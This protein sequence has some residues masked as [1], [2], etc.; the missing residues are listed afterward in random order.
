[1]ETNLGGPLSLLCEHNLSYLHAVTSSD[2]VGMMSPG[3]L[4]KIVFD[5]NESG[6]PPKLVSIFCSNVFRQ[7]SIIRIFVSHGHAIMELEYRSEWEL[8]QS[9]S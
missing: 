9:A 2:Q 3:S 7:R 1:M 6:C 5:N 8:L 4:G